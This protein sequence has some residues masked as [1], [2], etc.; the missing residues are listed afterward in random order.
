MAW[1]EN[2]PKED[3]PPEYLW[4]DVEGLEQWFKSVEAKREDGMPTVSGGGSSD[5]AD[6]EDPQVMVQNDV[7]TFLKG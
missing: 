1:F 2:L 3:I 6:G 7:A 5:E 4:E